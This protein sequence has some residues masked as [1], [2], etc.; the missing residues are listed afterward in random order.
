MAGNIEY[1]K[2]NLLSYVNQNQSEYTVIAHSANNKGVMGSGVA[3]AIIAKYPQVKQD[4]TIE[5]QR[6]G[7]LP[8]GKV[9]L[10]WEEGILIYTIVGQDGYGYDGSVYVDYNAL[11]QGFRSINTESDQLFTELAMPKIGAGLGGGDWQVIEKIIKEVF[12]N[13]KVIVYEL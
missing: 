11:K 6:S 4:Y 1:R 5:Y 3:K 2:G 12:T 8:L 10:S 13:K 9:V 7:A